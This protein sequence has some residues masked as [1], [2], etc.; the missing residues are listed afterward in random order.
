MRGANPF[1][2]VGN[3]WDDARPT[4]EEL[5]YKGD[6]D[7]ISMHMKIP[8]SERET[9]TG[10]AVVGVI[11]GVFAAV[12]SVPHTSWRTS[13]GSLLRSDLACRET[14]GV[15]QGG[16]KLPGLSSDHALDKPCLPTGWQIRSLLA[17]LR[18]HRKIHQAVVEDRQR[19]IRHLVHER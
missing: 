15:A 16:K 19:V 3:G 18:R 10:P 2:I 6:V 4:G 5:P 8:R 1:F 17:C 14:V 12:C 11:V 13:A 7:I 9:L